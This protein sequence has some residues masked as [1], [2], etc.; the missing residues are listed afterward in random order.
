MSLPANIR[1]NIGAPFPSTVKGSGPITISKQNGIWTVGFSIATIGGIPGNLNPAITEVL[2]WNTITQSFQVATLAQILT[3]SAPPTK[4]TSANSP[5]T[6]LPTDTFLYVDTAGGAI[7]IDL[8]A[9]A[10]RNGAALSIKDVT[11]HA[12]ANNITIKP[13]GGAAPETLDGYTNA[14]PLVLQANYDGVRLSPNTLSYVID[15]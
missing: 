11:G 9:A 15:P 14:A 1:V 6:P 8:A 7:E 2:V 3:L 12:A 4:I 13:I 5:Y 10:S